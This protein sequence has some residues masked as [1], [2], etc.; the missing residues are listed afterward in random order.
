MKAKRLSAVLSALVLSV[1]VLCSA[2]VFATEETADT[3][4]AETASAI[5]T[6]DIPGWP[7]G[8]DITSEA[9]VVMEESTGTILYSKNAD[10][11][12]Y[13]S[14]AVKIMTCLLALENSSITDEVVM[15]ATG[16]AGATDGGFNIAAQQDE[17]FTV[18]QCLYAIMLASANDISLQIAEHVGGTVE[19]FVALMNSRAAELGCTNTVFTNPTGMPDENQHVTAHDMA[20][21][22]RAAMSNESFR[23]IA[24][25]TSYTIPATNISGGDRALTGNFPMTNPASENYYEGCLGGKEGFTEASGSTLVCEAE[26][27]GLTLV[28]VVLKGASGQTVPEAAALLDYGFNN[29]ELQDL[30]TDDFSVISGGTVVVP[31]GT[32]ADL[33]TT[34]EAASGDGITR[35]YYYNGVGVGTASVENAVEEDNTAAEEGALNLAA[36]QTFSD[37]KSDLPYFL[38][39]GAGLVVIILLFW[40]MVVMIKKK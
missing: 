3:A 31:T 11:A 40:R 39:P 28:C 6:N 8:S 24:S 21:I 13:P 16:V 35:T 25:A 5:V 7:Q 30:G 12:L 34:E 15:T 33:L 26:R 22:T 14:A 27:N 10:E 18:E 23:T 19:N 20:L 4:A 37:S 29:F 1:S 38:I 32:T 2:P 9:A 36:A 17:I